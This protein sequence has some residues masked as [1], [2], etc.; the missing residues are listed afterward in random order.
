MPLLVTAHS[1]LG[2]VFGLQVG[3]PGW[4]SAL[5]APAFVVMAG[6]SGVGALIVVAA[7]MRRVLG[8]RERLGPEVFRWLGNLLMILLAVYLYFTLVEWLTTAYAAPRHEANALRAILAGRYAPVYWASIA[9][10]VLPFGL[11]VGQFF[12]RRHSLALTVMS[13]LLVNVAAL[14]KR[15]L[16]VVPS[17]TH[18]MLLPYAEGTYT[19]TWVEYAVTAGLFAL[20]TLLYT[21]AAKI[22]PIME[23]PE[24]HEPA[25]HA[26]TATATRSRG[27]GR[28]LRSLVTLAMVAGGF[29]L[30]AVS[31]FRFAAPLGAPTSPVF[32]DPRVPW[33][34]TLFI[35]GVM[36][37]FLAAVTY[38]LLP[39]RDEG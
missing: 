1:T 3:R 15:Y 14:G 13:G 22:F 30:Q 34:P 21:V 23:V 9:A 29:A 7:I 19:P 39:A 36:L 32:S 2:F 5:Q 8:E 11:L 18:G 37:V 35:V 17:Q 26:A 24:P 28:R 12:L 33:A 38:E 4:H 27:V 31:Y 10:L 6:V 16:I 25:V 20:G